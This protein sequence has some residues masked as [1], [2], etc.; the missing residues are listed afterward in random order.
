MMDLYLFYALGV[1]VDENSGRIIVD[2][3]DRT[4][5][6]NI[7]AIGD[8]ANGRPELTPPAIRAGHLLARRLFGGSKEKMNYH[9]IPTTVFSPVEYGSVGMSE[10]AAIEKYGKEGIEVY[11]REAT[12][13]EY[14]LPNR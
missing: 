1:Q 5:V 7:F 11:H 2:D 3:Y 10:N 4:N 9:N 13:L 14:V 8:C 6:S 12:P